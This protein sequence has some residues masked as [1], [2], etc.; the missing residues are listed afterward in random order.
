MR[1]LDEQQQQNAPQTFL[2][3]S[4]RRVSSCRVPR[5]PANLEILRKPSRLIQQKLFHN[6]F[7]REIER[8]ARQHGSRAKRLGG[9]LV[10][11]LRTFLP[12]GRSWRFLQPIAAERGYETA[13][14]FYW[15]SGFVLLL[16][17]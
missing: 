12:R 7:F 15:Y 14:N 5:S 13:S 3:G 10:R 4:L 6:L 11:P 1:L 17:G 16:Y 8:K 2:A 9:G